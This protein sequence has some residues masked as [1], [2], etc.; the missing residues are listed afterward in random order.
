MTE[1]SEEPHDLD[2]LPAEILRQL[3]TGSGRRFARFF[4]AA[5]GSIPWVGGLIAASAALSGERDQGRINDL[6]K[7]WLESHE[8]RIREL[9]QDVA[10]IVERLEQFGPTANQRLADESYLALVHQG[11]RVWDE[12]ATREKRELVRTLLTNSGATTL[13][14]DDVV[15]LFIDWI[16]SYHEAHFAVI[17]AIYDQPGITRGAIWDQIRGARPREDSA[18]ADLYKLLIRDLSTGGV[19]RQH[20]EVTASGEFVAKRRGGR[21]ST[22]S[23]TLKTAFDD[24]DPYVLTELGKQFV[25]YAIEDAAPQIGGDAETAE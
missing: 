23:S 8:A 16:E 25:H 21:R 3:Q 22:S 13:C 5:L 17:R 9:M 18:E 2:P 15:R 24:S 4:L 12:A 14:S 10:Q 7:Q 20:R 1:P 11:F 19:I 6:Q